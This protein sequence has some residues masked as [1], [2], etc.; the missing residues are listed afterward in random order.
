MVSQISVSSCG[1]I[2]QRTNLILVLLPILLWGINSTA[3]RMS[4]LISTFA[5]KTM[6]YSALYHNGP[7]RPA[8][9]WSQDSFMPC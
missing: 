3:L 7:V 1:Y 6:T 2:S 5:E 8:Y 9:S 4:V